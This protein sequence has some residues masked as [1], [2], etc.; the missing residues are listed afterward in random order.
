MLPSNDFAPVRE[1]QLQNLE[2]LLLQPDLE[3]LLAQLAGVQVRLEDSK[4]DNSSG[5]RG[6]C[7]G[8]LGM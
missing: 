2:G 1:Q 3:A 8:R 4:A 6:C 5:W 7:H